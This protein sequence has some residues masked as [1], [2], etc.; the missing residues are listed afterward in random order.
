MK[1]TNTDNVFDIQ[2]IKLQVRNDNPK[3]WQRDFNRFEQEEGSSNYN[4]LS[5][6]K[7]AISTKINQFNVN[8]A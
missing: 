4:K 7:R 6:S 5:A 3:N 2:V 1:N 8:S